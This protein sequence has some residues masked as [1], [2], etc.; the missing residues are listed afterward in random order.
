[1]N[2]VKIP[3][4]RVIFPD[5]PEGRRAATGFF[6]FPIFQQVYIFPGY[7]ARKY[8]GGGKPYAALRHQE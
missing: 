3:R 1:M 7:N 2:P 6:S 5:R 4:G 8:N